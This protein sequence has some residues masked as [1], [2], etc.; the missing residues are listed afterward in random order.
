MAA[1]P[2][3]SA[4]ATTGDYGADPAAMQGAGDRSRRRSVRRIPDAALQAISEIVRGTRYT[5][6]VFRR[7]VRVDHC[8]VFCINSSILGNNASCHLYQLVVDIAPNG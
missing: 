3:P 7:D 2:E 8:F 1:P 5:G 6:F 4:K